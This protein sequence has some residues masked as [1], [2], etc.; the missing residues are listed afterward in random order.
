MPVP[1]VAYALFQVVAT[2]ITVYEAYSALEEVFDAV[3]DFADDLEK[4]KKELDKI[5]KSIKE[6]IEDNIEGRE[7]VS[8][9]KALSNM[10][11]RPTTVTGR[12]GSGDPE[13]KR[14]I[15]QSI[16]F[17]KAISKVCEKADNMPVLTVRRKEKGISLEKAVKAK[18]EIIKKLIGAGFETLADIELEEFIIVRQ[19]QL[20]ASFLF[21]FIDYGVDW[22]SPLKAEVSFG[23]G[24]RSKRARG[25]F[26]PFKDPPMEFG[27]KLK[28]V[29]YD[30]NPF[31]PA[32]HRAKGSISADLVI[33]DYRKEPVG[34]KNLFAIVEIK[35]PKDK[36][37]TK[38]IIN[39]HRLLN[40]SKDVKDKLSLN[41]FNDNAVNSGG[42]IALFRF[43]E[44]ST[45]ANDNSSSNANKNRNSGKSR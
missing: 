16:P 5:F 14:A 30:L 41:K 12:V 34:K 24:G 3:D 7:E 18:S 22:K 13:I 44:D 2:A 29:G 25:S 4:A 27:T 21:E 33:P 20:A 9:L 31:Y 36:I 10:D 6:E 26:E 23:P 37:K 38:Q 15:K 32:P 40:A 45:E 42:R 28:R 8:G 35:F 1:F 11:V 17:R 43:P 19:K 39:Y